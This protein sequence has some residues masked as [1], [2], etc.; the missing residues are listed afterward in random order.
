MN[1]GKIMAELHAKIP[2]SVFGDD[3]HIIGIPF[4]LAEELGLPHI[5]WTHNTTDDIARRLVA[6]WNLLQPY[7]TKDIEDPFAAL[8]RVA[9]LNRL[10]VERT[11]LAFLKR[12]ELLAALEGL[13]EY[14][15]ARYG[16][17]DEPKMR[18]I[19]ARAS[20][21]VADAK[22]TQQ[23]REELHTKTPWYCEGDAIYDNPECAG[24]PIAH[25]LS[26][27]YGHDD[28]AV[29]ARRIVA[30]VNHCEGMDTE[31]MEIGSSLG[32]TARV[33]LDELEGKCA[34]AEHERNELK[35]E[36][37][38][39]RE[40][41]QRA[42]GRWYSAAQDAAIAQ[43]ERDV[44]KAHLERMCVAIS[45]FQDAEGVMP[46]DTGE[47]RDLQSAL[48]AA[49]PLLGPDAL[50]DAARARVMA[51]VPADKGVEGGAE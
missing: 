39:A 47:F 2:L 43:A 23:A 27:A 14:I 24:N 35:R 19:M 15:Y 4:E 48:Q 17:G 38:G 26:M 31:G 16:E 8:E 9:E 30:C 37:F 3:K 20:F 34:D 49:E 50:N 12:Y 29:D 13:H 42:N 6:C 5:Q 36:L 41:I 22:G 11:G 44:L 7:A 18:K 33:Y 32:R 1:K 51:A 40:S 10:H 45:A 21:A 28:N 25:V 46:A